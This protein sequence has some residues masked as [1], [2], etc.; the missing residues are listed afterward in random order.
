MKQS[1][2]SRK[3]FGEIFTLTFKIYF[4]S[5]WK[6][7]RFGTLIM[8]VVLL[9]A[10][11]VIVVL[12]STI[13]FTGYPF[14]NASFGTTAGL[15]ASY[16]LFYAAASVFA[17]SFFTSYFSPK[18]IDYLEEK[19]RS[20]NERRQLISNVFGRV[21]G[22]QTAYFLIYLLVVVLFNYLL[23]LEIGNID[24]MSLVTGNLSGLLSYLLFSAI[25][26]LVIVAIGVFSVFTKQTALFE[27][28]RWFGA[29]SKAV[30]TM[31]TGKFWANI[32]YLIVFGLVLN[33]G[34]YILAVVISL[35]ALLFAALL[36][37]FGTGFSA[38]AFSGN[39]ALIA[40]GVVLGLIV[41]V[42]I[43][44]LCALSSGLT[45]V[46]HTLVYFNARTASENIPFPERD[47]AVPLPDTGGD[48]KA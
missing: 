31:V 47:A 8:S 23:Y 40:G 21:T 29:L 6:N 13:N 11:P 16:I 28:R 26:I 14:M 45:S 4:G 24:M 35:I 12:L 37:G 2:P 9:F 32:G 10:V 17:P 5:F 48:T 30:R 41:F 42:L 27:H 19:Q 22:A 34:L 33:F 39:P 44:A 46:F 3:T 7:I 25:Y 15:A 38:M 43:A 36:F 1:H 18:T 20:E